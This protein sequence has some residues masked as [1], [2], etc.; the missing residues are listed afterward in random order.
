MYDIIIIGS[1]IVGSLVAYDLSRYRL[2]VAVLEKDNDVANGT[3]MA[4]SAIVHAG[5]DPEDGTMKALLNVRGARMYPQLCRD[6]NCIIKNTGAFIA[7]VGE[8]EEQVLD[9]LAARAEKRGIAC[10]LLDGDTARGLEQ[11]LSDN[12]TKVLS[13]PETCI[14]Y[15]WEVAYAAMETA[16]RNGVELFLN[17]EVTGIDKVPEGYLVKSGTQAYEARMVINA[18]GTGTAAI[19][20]MVSD[21]VDFEPRPRRGEYFVIDADID[22]VSRVIFPVPTAKGKGVLAVPT[23]HGNTLLGPTSEPIEDADKKETSFAGLE[24]VRQ[25]LQKTMKN[26]PLRNVI[27]SFA[28]I[29][30]SGTSADFLIEELPDAPAFVHAACI[31]SPGLASAPAIAAYIRDTF[32]GK[33]MPLEENPDAV[34]TRPAPVVMKNL[35]PA[36]RDAMIRRQPLYARIICRCEQIS[37][38]EI[39]DC[40]HGPCGARSIKAVKKRVR[41][42]M[43]RCQGGF[44]EPRVAA[45]LARE[46]HIPL[47]EVLLDSRNS[48]ILE[49]ENR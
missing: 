37:E 34:M 26:P 46:L 3:T 13:I 47:T 30:A 2:K 15:P 31:D 21:R 7:A 49:K 17:T 16:I 1:G 22:Y 19:D 45:I 40:I 33:Y 27:R 11:N 24:S 6:L 12:V 41:P 48:R 29:R 9:V 18:A 20:H 36:E 23:V 10:E 5:Y 14:I 25:Q 43:G 28:G 42:G 32:V 38:Q 44:C 35:T 4:N 39:I 8:E